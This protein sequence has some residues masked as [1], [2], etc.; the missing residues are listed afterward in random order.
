MCVC[1]CVC[2]VC[3][4]SMNDLNDFLDFLIFTDRHT[5]ALDMPPPVILGYEDS[6]NIAR[7][8]HEYVCMHTTL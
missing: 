1:V 2:V 3:C 8:V 5:C 6:Y 7:T 4:L